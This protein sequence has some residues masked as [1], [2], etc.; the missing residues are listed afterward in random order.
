MP[1]TPAPSAKPQAPQ[2]KSPGA[3][4]GAAAAPQAAGANLRGMNYADGKKAV[5]PGATPAVPAIPGVP[6][7]PAEAV[8][9]AQQSVYSASAGATLGEATTAYNDGD[10]EVDFDAGSRLSARL[11]D[12]GLSLS[13]NPGILIK[14]KNAPDFRLNN[15]T[16]S[17]SEGRFLTEAAAAHFDVLGILGKIGTWKINKVLDQKLKPLLPAVVQRA[18]YSPR[19]DPDLAGTIQQMTKMFDF[20][21]TP[22][23]AAAGGGMAGK[24]KDASAGL[25]VGLPKE[26]SVPLGDSGMELVIEQGTSLNLDAQSIGSVAQP[27]VQSLSLSAGGNGIRIRPKDGT[28]KDFKELDM[29][30]VT[31]GK[32]GTFAF[33]YDLSVEQMANGLIGLVE[34]LGMAAGQ[35]V[36]GEAP[37]VKL[38]S[39]RA[40]I[41]AKLQAEVPP[42]FRALIEQYDHLVPGL[43]LK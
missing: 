22:G 8:G 43:S 42:R 16:W 39:I 37:D 17:F 26:F 6:Q 34:L 41:D 19:T 13:C 29:K 4:A 5:Q 9:M 33:N 24:L 10:I 36:S 15:V 3:P 32:G 35:P 20:A 30:S 25:G 14:A 21:Q 31:I 23:A 7:S 2:A 40:E 38:D 12:G 1:A 27:V 11:G 28:F 18:G